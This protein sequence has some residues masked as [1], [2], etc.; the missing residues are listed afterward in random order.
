VQALTATLIDDR[1]RVIIGHSLGSVVAWEACHRL[2][3]RVPVLIT[4]GSPL[5]LGHVVY[6]R[7]MPQ[8]PSWPEQIDRWVNVAHHDDFIAVEPR[9]AALFP[10]TDGRVVE[11]HT[12]T[13]KHEHH[14]IA[15]YLE[16]PECGLA[17]AEA[18]DRSP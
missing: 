17:V 9:L 14:G 10:S 15:G 6:D 5:G 18:L 4:L 1:T 7:L 16:R 8:P 11:D 13:S 2:P 12:L 3:R